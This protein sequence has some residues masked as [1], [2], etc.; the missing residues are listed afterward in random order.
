MCAC[1][2]SWALSVEWALAAG[3]S[4]AAP[5]LDI[6]MPPLAMQQAELRLATRGPKDG[7]LVA[8]GR[9]AFLVACAWLS[10]VHKIGLMRLCDMLT[11]HMASTQACNNR[12]TCHESGI[13][14]HYGKMSSGNQQRTSLQVPDSHTYMYTYLHMMHTY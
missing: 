5:V 1:L 6:H 9:T 3:V 10:K 2:R 12:V 14:W 11:L 7:L 13:T 8:V 4:P